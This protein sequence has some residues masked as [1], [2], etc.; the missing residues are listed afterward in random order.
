MSTAKVKG[1][2]SHLQVK[3]RRHR[4]HVPP[5]QTAGGVVVTPDTLLSPVMVDRLFWRTGFGPTAADRAAWT[6]K[7]LD[8]CVEGI[9]SNKG[10]ALV[11]PA[12]TNGGAALDPNAD[13]VDLVLAWVDRMIRSTNPFL[14]RMQFFWHGHF[15][16]SRMVVSPP[17]LLTRQG[18][19]FR[20]Y[21]DFGSNPNADF[22]NM[23][24]EVGEDPAML[25]FLDG[26]E[27]RIGS[28]NE[29]YARELME[30]FAL[31][32]FDSGGKANYSE[33]DVKFLAKALT[34]WTINDTDPDHAVA[35][36]NPAASVQGTVRILGKYA[37]FNHRS[38]VDLILTQPN[39]ARFLILKLWSEFI[40][41]PPD[42]ATLNGLISTYT[43]GGYKLR[44]V[45]K[46]I[47]THPS[48][49]DS[50]NEPNMIKP[51]IVYLVGVHRTLGLPIVDTGPYDY[52]DA[53]GQVPYFPPTVAGWEGGLSWLNTNTAL[54]R[55]AFASRAVA[56]P[57]VAP[58]DAIETPQ[59]AL[60][61][62]HASVGSPWLADSSREALL[63][64][65]GAA[66]T[67]TKNRRIARQL[68]LRAMIL[69]GPD[70]QVM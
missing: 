67:T 35:V 22:K 46:K 52:L 65:A 53:M 49:F 44:P 23:C 6:G 24:Y 15:A 18:E 28:P 51:P 12:P 25:R 17:Q 54:A 3:R 45:L 43:S 47:L 20:K 29:N 70:G 41:P 36:F 7:K 66:P 38:A 61:R 5:K 34:G 16:C 1:S 30:L 56:K 9:L 57:A 48:L 58:T 42:A 62:A 40:V 19:L 68:M 2:K 8:E 55:F 69:A 60:E 64:Y 4:T 33:E 21:S 37:R 59:G 39:H 11:G 10:A 63:A 14:E 32:V 50:I 27:N 26:E 13:D 31:G